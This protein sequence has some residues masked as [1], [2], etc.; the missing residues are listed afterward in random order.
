[1]NRAE[2]DLERELRTALTRRQPSPGLSER[3]L[4]RVEEPRE[5]WW[6]RLVAPF[7]LPVMRWAVTCLMVVSIAGGTFVYQRHQ[8][9]VARGLA[10][11]QQLMIALHIASSK[12]QSVQYKVHTIGTGRGMQN[13]SGTENR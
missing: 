8:Q 3:I 9:E 11:K 4:A 2:R 6:P 12:M 10:A 1:M 5:S 7:R 13:L